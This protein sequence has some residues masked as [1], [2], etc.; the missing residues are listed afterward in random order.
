MDNSLKKKIAKWIPTHVSPRLVVWVYGV[1]DRLIYIKRS[2]RKENR[3]NNDEVLNSESSPYKQGYIENQSE[4]KNVRFGKSTMAFSGCEI[5]AVYNALYYLN[6]G[7]GAALIGELIEEFEKSGAAVKGLIG[8]SPASIRRHLLKHGI[9][10][11][12]VWKEDNIDPE[13]E[14]AIATVYNDKKTLY[15][16]IHTITFTKDENGFRSHNARSRQKYYPTLKEAINGV[17]SDPKMI[18]AIEIDNK[19]L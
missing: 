7:S 6:K 9:K 14:L 17:S 2:I 4:W 8:S 3:I 1:L 18:C 12:I 13:C 11:R 15:S 10:S 16:Q 19:N 5:M